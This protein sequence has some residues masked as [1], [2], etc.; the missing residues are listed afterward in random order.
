ML[1]KNGKVIYLQ[2]KSSNLFRIKRNNFNYFKSL[3]FVSLS[4]NLLF[5]AII[6]ALKM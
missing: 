1:N 5:I 4:F 3:F 2:P 6:I